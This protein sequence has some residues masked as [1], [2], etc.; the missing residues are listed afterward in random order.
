[1]KKQGLVYKINSFEGLKP[2]LVF[3]VKL[4]AIYLSWRMFSILMGQ[5]AEPIQQR[6]W[7]WASY[8]WEAFNSVIRQNLIF[9]SKGLLELFGYNVVVIGGNLIRVKGFSGLG[10]GNYCLALELFL[11][12]AAL[13]ISYPVPVKHKLWFIP[14]GM[15][16]IHL[17]N[18]LR[19]VGLSLLTVY[20]P[21]YADF[22]HHFTFRIIVFLYILAIYYWFI[23]RYGT[24]ETATAS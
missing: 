1:M 2:I 24:G 7:P 20:L 14:L 22:N 8:Y 18:V 13:V 6:T 17:L 11:L 15:V 4:L 3:L 19:V 16:S 12:F 9:L 23:H 5:E 21:Q 10:V